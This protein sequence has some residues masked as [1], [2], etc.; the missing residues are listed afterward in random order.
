MFL[1]YQKM[2]KSDGKRK[3]NIFQNITCFLYKLQLL[4]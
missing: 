4:L 1:G 2:Q 3:K